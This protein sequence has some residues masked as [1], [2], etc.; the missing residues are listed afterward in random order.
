ML[1]APIPNTKMTSPLQAERLEIENKKLGR[2]NTASLWA[3]E[4]ERTNWKATDDLLHEEREQHVTDLRRQDEE[5]RSNNAGLREAEL[6]MRQEM[7]AL[8]E[9]LLHAR[10]L[11]DVAVAAQLEIELEEATRKLSNA[12]STI[13]KMRK[14]KEARGVMG[15]QEQ[16]RVQQATAQDLAASVQRHETHL[17]E[18]QE[19]EERAEQEDRDNERHTRKTHTQAL[20][21]GREKGSQKKE[22]QKEMKQKNAAIGEKDAAIEALQVR[23]VSE[24]VWALERQAEMDARQDE[25]CMRIQ[26]GDARAQQ[27]KQEAVWLAQAT[28]VQVAEAAAAHTAVVEKLKGSERELEAFRNFQTKEKGAYKDCVRMCYFKLIDM[29]VPTNQLEGVVKAVLQLVGVQAKNLPSRGS[30]QNMR[31]EMGHVADAAAGVLLAQASNATG[32]S[33]DTTKRQR[34]LAA[35][36]IHFREADGTL[37][38][39]CI[40]LSCMSSGTAVAKV[41]RY[42][43]KLA[44]VQAA[45]RLSVPDFYGNVAAFDRVTLLDLVKNWCSD[46]CITERN[47]AK[48]VEERKGKEARAREGARQLAELRAPGCALQL[49]LAGGPRAD[50]ASPPQLTMGQ[51][52]GGEV[53]TWVRVTLSTSRLT[54]SAASQLQELESSALHTVTESAETPLPKEMERQ[55]VDAEMARMLG[56]EWWGGLRADEQLAICR[57]WAATCNAHRWVNVG[58]GFD[59]GIKEAWDAIRAA[60]KAETVKLEV[61]QRRERQREQ[62]RRQEQQRR[63][64]QQQHHSRHSR[65]RRPLQIKEARRG[66]VSSMR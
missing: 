59:E 24:A 25:L 57:V 1:E 31:R 44:Q 38:C 45:A 41:Q 8:A 29:K 34:T 20:R 35:D 36:L 43:E 14:S 65:R 39:L 10:E 3:L 61:A 40:G 13:A 6:A 60:R 7:A 58:K 52:G 26:A 15:L 37:R 19:S 47:A 12:N 64:E 32:A 48:L 17:R 66:I 4:R 42:D 63:R 21:R 49:S 30:A 46:R 53:R 2:K 27:L 18:L 23:L 54:S 22:L 11:G 33:D 56:A 5:L 28:E 16:L 55:L 51:S 50:E 62:Q 9:Q